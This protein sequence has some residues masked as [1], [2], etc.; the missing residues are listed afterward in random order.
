MGVHSAVLEYLNVT[1]SSGRD[2][3]GRH[4]WSPVRAC[5]LAFAY[6]YS[7]FKM[8]WWSLQLLD[9]SMSQ[10]PALFEGYL[11]CLAFE[12]ERNG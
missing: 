8:E 10:L 6:W 1:H 5:S 12:I 7:L 4:S 2:A 9:S 3:R 11:S